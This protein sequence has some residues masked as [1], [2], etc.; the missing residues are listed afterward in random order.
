MSR[1]EYKK[2]KLET[3][4][5]ILR[6]ISQGTCKPDMIAHNANVS[7]DMLS[8]MLENLQGWGLLEKRKTKGYSNFLITT[9]GK[10]VLNKLDSLSAEMTAIEK[11]KEETPVVLS[12]S[13]SK[14]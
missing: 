9:K 6:V 14:A 4:L 5:D 12:T 10:R 1:I 11:G 7:E 3:Y 13:N 2:S 8:K